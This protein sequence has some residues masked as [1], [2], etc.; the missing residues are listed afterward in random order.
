MDVGAFDALLVTHLPDFA[1]EGVDSTKF[2]LLL[3]SNVVLYEGTP[4]QCCILG[5][6]QKRSS[7]PFD[8]GVQTLAVADYDS[9]QQF[10][11]I[12]DIGIVS[13]L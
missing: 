10:G 1:A 13:P 2:P 11:G 5:L 4:A 7:S 3:L 12:R 9:T 6:P 8:G